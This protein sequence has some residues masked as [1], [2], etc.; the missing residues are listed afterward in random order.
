MKNN[1]DFKKFLELKEKYKSNPTKAQKEEVQ[2]E[3][4]KLVALGYATPTLRVVFDLGIE[5]YRTIGL[6][7]MAIKVYDKD[8]SV[9]GIMR[10][11]YGADFLPKSA[12]DLIPF[13]ELVFDPFKPLSYSSSGVDYANLFIPS[14]FFSFKQTE[15]NM[16]DVVS[17]DT[18]PS[19]KAL[20]ENVFKTVDRMNYFTNWLAY[21]FQTKKKSGTSIISKGTQGTGKGVIFEEIIKYA[22]GERYVTTLDNEALKSRFNGE[23]EN[24]LFILANEIKADFREGNTIYERLKM[25]ITDPTI[26]FE[27]KNIKARSIPNFF[28]IWFHSNN[29]VPLQIQGGDRRYT[30]FNTKS[31]KLTEVSTEL[32]HEH[33]RFFIDEIKKERDSFIIDLMRLKYDMALATTPMP[34]DEKELIYEASMSKIEVMSDKIKKHDIEYFRD[35]VGDFYDS[36]D[37]HEVRQEIFKTM[38]IENTD[39]LII[40]IQKQFNGNYIKNDLSKVLYK[41][42]VN[43]DEKDRKIGLS[44]NKHFGKATLKN[45]SGNRFKFRTIDSDKNVNFNNDIPLE[46]IE[47]DGQIKNMMINK[48]NGKLTVD[49]QE[50]F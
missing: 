19:I 2:N 40:E 23:L 5:K 4:I 37:L 47:A 1:K 33:I 44:L 26:R 32:G 6:E 45:L 35:V 25:Y 11:T 14:K 13:K 24:K 3:V 22:V 12:T 9:R 41:I 38:I 48:N 30:V 20:F 36:S 21:G 18:Y 43:E 31:K 28:N 29:D 49:G 17:W 42:L 27:E 46:V 39:D 15:N 8:K 34:T 16:L 50:I 7:D 10:K